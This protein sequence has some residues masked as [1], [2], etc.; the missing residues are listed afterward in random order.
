M[1]AFASSI[2]RSNVRTR[3]IKSVGA[4]AFAIDRRKNSIELRVLE[5]IHALILIGTGAI[6]TSKVTRRA[7]ELIC[8]IKSRL[9]RA[10]VCRTGFIYSISIG[11]VANYT[12][13]I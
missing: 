4:F 6:C 9:A 13:C 2:L 1:T 3:L 7:N 5:A 12:I 8:L 11:S 10:A